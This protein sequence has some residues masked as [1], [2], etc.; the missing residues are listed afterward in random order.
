MAES[1]PETYR[2]MDLSLRVGEIL[3]SSGA[4]AADVKSTILA[5]T[6]ACG[7]RNCAVDISFT[8][9]SVSYQEEPDSAPET[10]MRVVQHRGLDFGAMSDI[11][12]MLRRLVSGRIDRAE[13]STIVND[14][15]SSKRPYSR[16]VVTVAAGF[17]AGGLS[18]LLGGD[19]LVFAVTVVTAVLIDLSG[20][21]LS[22]RRIPA[23]YGQILGALIA[24]ATAIGL[25]MV[26]PPARPSLI[27]ASGIIM[28]LAGISIVGAVQ[29]AL[30]G[31]YVTGAARTFE[32]ILLTGGVIGGVSIGLGIAQ[33]FGETLTVRIVEGNVHNLPSQLL[34]AVIATV[35]FAVTCQVAWKALPGLGLV[36]LFAQLLYQASIGTEWGLGLAVSSGIAAFGVGLVAFQ[37]GRQ[38]GAPPL[39]VVTVGVVALLPGGAIYRGLF[40]LLIDEKPIGVI[41]LISAIT[42]AVALAAGAILGEYIAQPLARTAG[43][44]ETRLSGPRLVGPLRQPSRSTT[45]KAA[46]RLRKLQKQ[47]QEEESGAESTSDVR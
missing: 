14:I 26:Y 32:A 22:A 15:T 2:A 29:D 1:A 9:L 17:M 16:R 45:R 27:I 28:L 38:I 44:L 47:E 43:R 31:Y 46:R 20:R 24:T 18:L 8:T 36:G 23:F 7:L 3:L 35:A 21:F 11:D 33:N 30:T 19:A 25:H 4:G 34:G 41:T 10:H 42:I 13:A 40:Q 12:R 6:S 39:V 5:V 37:V